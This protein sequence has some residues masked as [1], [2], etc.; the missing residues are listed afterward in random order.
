MAF[1]AGCL[2]DD[3]IAQDIHVT[4]DETAIDRVVRRLGSINSILEPPHVLPIEQ[5][6]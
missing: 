1:E 6:A 4:G 2:L 5:L 3:D